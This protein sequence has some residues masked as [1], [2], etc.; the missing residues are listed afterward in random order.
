MFSK[1][2]FISKVNDVYVSYELFIF[3][4]VKMLF[5]FVDIE[6]NRVVLKI[7]KIILIKI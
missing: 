4:G 1:F 5:F 2:E 6:M 3:E 7:N